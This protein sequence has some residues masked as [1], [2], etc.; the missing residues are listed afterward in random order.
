MRC[1]KRFLLLCVLCFVCLSAAPAQE[2][3]LTNLSSTIKEKLID[4]KVSSALV[5]E[6]LNQVSEDLKA[7][8][9]E[10]SQWKELSTNLSNSLVSINEELNS[11]YM[12]IEKQ[13]MQSKIK[14]KWITVL[15]V[16]LI[17][18]TIGMIAGYVIYAKGIKLPR[19]L[20]ILL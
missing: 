5:T 2:K 9:N 13:E 14:T 6:Q 8:Q 20:D 1:V 16:I 7:S 11:C 18:R 10:A 4:L 19:W 3:E 17:V 12:T 15:L